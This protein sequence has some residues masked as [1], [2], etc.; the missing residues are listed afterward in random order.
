MANLNDYID[1]NVTLSKSPTSSSLILSDPDDYPAGV[2]VTLIGYFVITQPDTITITGSFASPDIEWDGS[3]LTTATKALR[4]R[5]TGGFQQGT[6][7]IT[8]HVSAP[9]YDETILIKTFDL[10]YT[11]PTLEVT[12]NLDVFIPNLSV[13]D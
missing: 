7:S 3:E 13:T 2:D 5:A 4:L 9:G 12:D 10:S 1:F 6:Y 8:Y 11:S